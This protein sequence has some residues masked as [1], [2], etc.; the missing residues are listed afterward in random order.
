VR[1][2][3]QRRREAR[4]RFETAS[5]KLDTTVNSIP[6]RKRHHKDTP[7]SRYLRLFHPFCIQH[8]AILSSLTPTTKCVNTNATLC[9]MQHAITSRPLRRQWKCHRKP[10]R[11]TRPPYPAKS[12]VCM[13]D[14]TKKQPQQFYHRRTTDSTPSLMTRSHICPSFSSNSRMYLTNVFLCVYT[15]VSNHRPNSK[16]QFG[17]NQ[18]KEYSPSP[19]TAHP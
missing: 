6:Y 5:L 13:P 18:E 9:A 12:I 1:T 7:T 2:E 11:L 14:K 3:V 19:H 17:S 4:G 16:Q 8:S 15:A 10:R